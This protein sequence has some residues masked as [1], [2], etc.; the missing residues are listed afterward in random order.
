LA[1]ARETQS[2]PYLQTEIEI[3]CDYPTGDS[4]VIRFAAGRKPEFSDPATAVQAYRDTWDS[5]NAKRG[6]PRG[7]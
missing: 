5:L 4:N 3:V 7:E 2:C 6:F 1:V